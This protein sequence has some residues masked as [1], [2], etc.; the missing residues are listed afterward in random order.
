MGERLMWRRIRTALDT[1]PSVELVEPSAPT[2]V[3]VSP[4]ALAAATLGPAPLTDAELVK[5]LQQ[6]LTAARGT[7]GRL[8]EKLAAPPEPR[9]FHGCPGCAGL[10]RTV[11]EL[12]AAGRED[13]ATIA[14]L[15]LASPAGRTQTLRAPMR[16]MP[17]GGA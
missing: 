7:I 4:E 16:P 15:T 9:P 5:R 10:R 2:P 12:Q 14:R 6:E 3:A 11:A 13:R 8:N 1:D 17:D